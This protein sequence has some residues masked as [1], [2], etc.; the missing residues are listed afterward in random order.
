MNPEQPINAVARD[1]RN[2][3]IIITTGLLLVLGAIVAAYIYYGMQFAQHDEPMPVAEET[4]TPTP[5]AEAIM[6]ALES[7][8]VA[9]EEDA[10]AVFEALEAADATPT[11]DSA[12]VLEALDYPTE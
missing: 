10:N 7:A 2:I 12:Q 9:S 5:D 8:P 3:R 6:A 4:M 11:A 1:A